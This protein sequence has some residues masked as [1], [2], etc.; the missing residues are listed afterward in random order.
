MINWI[1][2]KLTQLFTLKLYTLHLHNSRLLTSLHIQYNRPTL[3]LLSHLKVDNGKN[4][5]TKH[6]TVNSVIF[7]IR[8]RLNCRYFSL[9]PSFVLVLNSSPRTSPRAICTCPSCNLTHSH[10]FDI[11]SRLLYRS[12][13][14]WPDD[15]APTSPGLETADQT[16]SS[17]LSPH[18]R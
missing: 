5:V 13:D 15:S 7:R 14:V 18:L 9:H 17:L 8:R 12:L 11:L 4:S 16:Q 3:E 10:H 1:I 2:T 6:W